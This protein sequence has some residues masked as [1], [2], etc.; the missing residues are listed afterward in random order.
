MLVTLTLSNT[1]VGAANVSSVTPSTTPGAGIAC[2]AAA[3]APPQ[4]IPGGGSLV[5]GWSC[6]ATDPGDYVLRASVAATDATSGAAL[7]VAVPTVPVA[8]APPGG[9]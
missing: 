7:A 2:T 6:A 9:P 8:V 4:A 1:G 3:P 5:F